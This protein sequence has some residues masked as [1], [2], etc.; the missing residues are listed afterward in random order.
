[1]FMNRKHRFAIFGTNNPQ[2]I[3][4]ENANFTWIAMIWPGWCV[5]TKTCLAQRCSALAERTM[6]KATPVV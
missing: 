4:H 1:M 6:R 5:Q 2:K 3:H